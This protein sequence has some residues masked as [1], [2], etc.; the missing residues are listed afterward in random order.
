MLRAARV[1][2]LVFCQAFGTLAELLNKLDSTMADTAAKTR[3]P[4]AFCLRKLMNIWKDL[5]RTIRI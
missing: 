1:L 5:G 2:V 3:V 4:S